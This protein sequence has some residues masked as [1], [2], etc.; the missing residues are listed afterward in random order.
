MTDKETL[1]ALLTSAGV[2][3]G[4]PDYP[5]GRKDVEIVEVRNSPGMGYTGFVS[6]WQF[7]LAGK[8]VGVGH[9]E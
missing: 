1:S 9:Y 6:T 8:L 7:T 4:P 3:F 2:P 5:S